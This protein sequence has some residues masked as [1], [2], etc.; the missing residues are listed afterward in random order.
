MSY[1]GFCYIIRAGFHEA[2]LPQADM[3]GYHPPGLHSF[4]ITLPH[5]VNRR[6]VHLPW[7]NDGSPLL[8]LARTSNLLFQI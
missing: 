3:N 6:S 7:A 4:P 8:K 5:A 2:A 1:A